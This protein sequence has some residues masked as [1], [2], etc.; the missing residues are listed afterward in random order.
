MNE[1]TKISAKNKIAIIHKHGRKRDQKK[2]VGT[3]VSP[4]WNV[5]RKMKAVTIITTKGI[6]F[7]LV[8][9]GK[10]STRTKN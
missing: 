2:K 6:D 5:R 9:T 10:L 1:Q 3:Q 4:L 8:Q 7:D